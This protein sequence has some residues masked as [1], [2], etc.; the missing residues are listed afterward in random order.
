MI[1]TTRAVVGIVQSQYGL[2]TTTAM[3]DVTELHFTSLVSQM[4]HDSGLGPR[5]GGISGKP[6]IP[7]TLS[8][9]WVQSQE[10][11]SE[12]GRQTQ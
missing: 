2:A 3:L 10:G 9:H 4:F 5:G 6:S 7:G 11:P 12:L 8:T 1:G